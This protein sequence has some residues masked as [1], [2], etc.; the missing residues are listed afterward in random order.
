[1]SQA[2]VITEPLGGGPLTRAL[3]AGE[4]PPHWLARQPR[5]P[6]EWTT[7]A[8]A[9][10]SEAHARG[11]LDALAPALG[12]GGAAAERLRRVAEGRGVV[13]TTGQQPGL[14]GGPIYTWSKAI[15]ALALAD[16]LER[17]TGIPVA[18]VFWAATDDADLVEASSTTLATDAGADVITAPSSGP[19]GAPASRVLLGDVQGLLEHLARASGSASYREPLDAARDAYRA[20]ATV[21]SAYVVLLRRLLEPLGIAVLDASHEASLTAA[22]TLLRAAQAGAAD[23]D[24][25][26]SMRD[27]EIIAAGF[28]PQVPRVEGRS[29]VFVWEHGAKRRLTIGDQVPAE[30]L[31]ANVLLRPVVERALLPTVAYVAGPAEL[32]YFAQVSAVASALGAQAPLAVPRWSTTI[33]EPQ[34]QRALA[35]LG[36]DPMDVRDPHAAEGRLAREALPASVVS[37]LQEVRNAVDQGLG[38]LAAEVGQDGLVSPRIVEGARAIMRHRIERLE[39]RFAAAVKHR[40]SRTRRDLSAARGALWPNGSRQER[41]LNFLPLLARQGP[42][43]LWRMREAAAE[44]ARALIGTDRSGAG[45]RPGS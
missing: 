26:L 9:V 11:W 39:R 12:A 1:M 27:R 13:V 38:A 25:A 10:Q 43:L 37:R 7:R 45:G 17:A 2:R 18:P 32:A 23:V 29:L 8:T 15:S 14:F 33:L 30:P 36:M 19:D 22:A 34:V 44:H 40:E 41:A 35:R 4:T 20:G 31:S 6:A 5:T 24:Q 3:L 21:G 42:D 16:E 28:T